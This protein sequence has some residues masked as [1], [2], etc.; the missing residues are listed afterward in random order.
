MKGKIAKNQQEQIE[1]LCQL[2]ES[3]TNKILGQIYILFNKFLNPKP[4]KRVA[5]KTNRL[6]AK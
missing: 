2:K 6:K 1:Q 4:K 5:D 3:S